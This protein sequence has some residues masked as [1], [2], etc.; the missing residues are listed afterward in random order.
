MKYTKKINSNKD[1]V[2]LYKKGKFVSGK[3]CVVYFRKNN[4]K[5]NRLGISTSKKIGNAVERSRA[6]RVIRA[7]YC[8][9]EQNFPIGYDI[10]ITARQGTTQ[11][12]SYHISSFLKNKVIPLMV[13]ESEKNIYSVN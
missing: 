12:K 9:N 7:A 5:I 13:K 6:R 2:T 10:I 4:K 3:N 1:F 8:E 11:C